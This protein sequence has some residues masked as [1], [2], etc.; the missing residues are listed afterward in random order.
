MTYQDLIVY[1]KPPDISYD[2]CAKY[3]HSSKRQRV[4]NGLTA[5]MNVTAFLLKCFVRV[6]KRTKDKGGYYLTSTV[7]LLHPSVLD[8]LLLMTGN[9]KLR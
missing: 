3:C 9:Y 8:V 5:E 6:F 4:L 1:N 2:L 7:G